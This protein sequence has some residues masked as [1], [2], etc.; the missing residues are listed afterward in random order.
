MG[1][2]KPKCVFEHAQNAQIQSYHT[3]TQSHLSICSPLINSIGSNDFLADC[4]GPDQTARIGLPSPHMPFEVTP[5]PLNII[6]LK[7]TIPLI[8][9]SFVHT[10]ILKKNDVSAVCCGETPNKVF[11]ILTDL[12]RFEMFNHFASLLR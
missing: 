6:S 8:L 4:E 11:P 7:Q 1:G 10:C 5:F 12:L 3:H 9:F 2:I